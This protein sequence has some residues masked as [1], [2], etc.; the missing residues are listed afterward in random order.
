MLIGMYSLHDIKMGLYLAPFA[1]R[2]DVEAGRQIKAA[3]SDPQ[4]RNA[5]FVLSPGD[6]TLSQR[7]I[8]DD[9][10]GRFEPASSDSVYSLRDFAP[11]TVTP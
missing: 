1:A 4:M 8:Y 10:T 2:N 9:E 11:S 3:M 7:G 6:F 5:D